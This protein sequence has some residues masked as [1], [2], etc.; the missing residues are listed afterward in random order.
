MHKH[1]GRFVILLLGWAALI[2]L[3]AHA[4]DYYV[5]PTG[6]DT[7]PGTLAAPWRHIAYAT[8]GGSYLCPIA[9]NNPNKLKAGDTLYLRAGVYNESNIRFANSGAVGA[10]ITVAS[11]PGETAEID[12]GYTAISQLTGKG[13]IFFVDGPTIAN[14]S[15]NHVVIER[16]T[17]RNARNAMVMV[18]EN[19]GPANVVIRDN[20][21]IGLVSNDNSGCVF[22][23]GANH[24]QVT[25][26]TMHGW[27]CVAGSSCT[28]AAGV[29]IFN[30]KTLAIRNNHFYGLR[31]GM[32]WKS[33][34][35][36]NEITIF[37]NNLVHDAHQ[38]AMSNHRGTIIRN[39]LMYNLTGSGVQVFEESASCDRLVT[40]DNRITHNTIVTAP[41][42]IFLTRSQAC[43]GAVNT[44]VLDNL[45]VDFTNGEHR[46]LSVWPYYVP[47]YGGSG[48]DTSNTTFDHNL[49]YAAAY[50]SPI[51]VLGNY[52]AATA[53]PLTGTGNIQQAPVFIDAANGDYTLTAAS[54]G[55][56]AASDGT[57]MGA[58]ICAVGPNPTCAGFGDTLA[59]AAP[60]NLTVQ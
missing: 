13:H 35:D 54:P 33:G 15:V 38:G 36:N 21:F 58:L 1:A 25:N 43:A 26:N 29:H 51:R 50:P 6:S 34:P 31:A 5:S 10:P 40:P 20:E 49:I 23:N 14:G 59:P 37:E 11:H 28:S 2:P 47:Q 30:G 53:A 60:S 18:G 41:T 48:V 8:C 19:Y 39:N 12:G 44:V 4:A 46:G 57:D 56:N 17:M 32:Y 42:G 52:Y 55:K 9:T 3:T 7:N 45:I 16:L 24:V 27:S 22:V